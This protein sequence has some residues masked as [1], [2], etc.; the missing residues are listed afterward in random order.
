MDDL[1]KRIYYPF[2]FLPYGKG[3]HYILQDAQDPARFYYALY[4][5]YRPQ[6]ISRLEV[7]KAVIEHAYQLMEYTG[8]PLS[9]EELTKK[10][11]LL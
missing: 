4:P 8:Q 2:A 7:E 9:E 1:Q 5:T 11:P 3:R 6:E 10:L